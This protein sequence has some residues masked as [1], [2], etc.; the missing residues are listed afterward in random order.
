MGCAAQGLRRARMELPAEQRR[1]K[2]REASP[3]LLRAGA[4]GV[5]M[6]AVARA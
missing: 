6:L 4:D 5:R 1:A 2:A 3:A